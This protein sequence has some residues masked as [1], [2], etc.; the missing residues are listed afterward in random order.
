MRQ[1]YSPGYLQGMVFK[2]EF[3]HPK[4]EAQQCFQIGIQ[5]STK[6]SYLYPPLNLFNNKRGPRLNNYPPTLSLIPWI[7]PRK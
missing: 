3:K 4:F 6:N 5:A 2:A 1:I 7:R